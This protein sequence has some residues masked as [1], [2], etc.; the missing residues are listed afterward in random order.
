M[1][2]WKLAP[3]S[4]SVAK[5]VECYWFLEKEPD[6][7]VFNYPKLNPDPAAHLILADKEQAYQYNQDSI[8][9]KGNG[10][11]WIFPHCKTLEM[12]NSQPFL[13]NGS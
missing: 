1:K 9:A 7:K 8:S 3:K 10:S 5:Y 12:D 11:H 6:D 13:M 2:N 4:E